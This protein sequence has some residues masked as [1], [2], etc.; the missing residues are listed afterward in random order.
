V[1]KEVDSKGDEQPL[2]P[3]ATDD[4]PR[5]K[6]H[7]QQR[8]QVHPQPRSVGEVDAKVLGGKSGCAD[9]VEPFIQEMDQ[10]GDRK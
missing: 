9:P 6:R 8:W 1:G 2:R 7:E 3:R 5:Y 4:Q 10:I